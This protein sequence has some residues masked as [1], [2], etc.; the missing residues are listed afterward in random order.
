MKL[1]KKIAILLFTAALLVSAP[2][3]VT[4][5][6]QPTGTPGIGKERVYARSIVE[7]VLIGHGFAI[8]PT[9]E[10]QYHILDV[11]A[12]KTA[13]VSSSSIRS[14]LSQNKTRAEIATDIRNYIQ[15]APSTAK[16]DIKFAGQAYALYI[17][18]Y[19]NLSLNGNVMTLPPRGTNY[20]TFTPTTVGNI[21]ISMSDYEGA[22][23]S[24]GTLTM[25]GTLYNV[26]LTS[27]VIASRVPQDFDGMQGMGG[28]G[29]HNPNGIFG[30][31]FGGFGQH[32]PKR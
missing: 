17:T 26:L 30:R 15:N 5:F 10:S 14:L 6:A 31:I 29:P 1:T 21:S 23:V 32:N 7:P 22:V 9:S 8:N 13:N 27:P 18:S 11:T 2:T 3:V 4:V 19:D 20:S 24:T 12:I 25:N 16:G 28:F